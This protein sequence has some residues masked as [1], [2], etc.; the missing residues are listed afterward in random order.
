[1]KCRIAKNLMQDTVDG[2]LRGADTGFIMAHLQECAACREDYRQTS[3]MLEMLRG[4][5]VPPPSAG[6]ADRVLN[7]ATRSRPATTG[8]RFKYATG[9]IAASLVAVVV[10]ISTMTGQPDP[11]VMLIGGQVKTVRVA[12]ESPRAI[13]GIKVTIDLSDNLEIEGY[14][15]QQ[16]ISWTTRLEQGVNL[17]ALPVN[18]IATGEGQIVARVGLDGDEKVYRIRTRNQAAGNVS[19]DYKILAQRPIRQPAV[20]L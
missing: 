13:D 7:H 3:N 5:P 16:A 4:I 15:D 18:A 20:N 8:R 9:G 1:M 10:M 17:I 14:A 2:K 12:I 11:D 19:S 6:F